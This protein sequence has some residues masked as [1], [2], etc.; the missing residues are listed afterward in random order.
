MGKLSCRSDFTGEATLEG[1][2]GTLE[3]WLATLS[4]F[5]R[6]LLDLI[7]EGA[8][9]EA[10]ST[11]RLTRAG[12]LHRTSVWRRLIR[13]EGYGVVRRP[14]G[15]RGGWALALT[16][17]QTRL[18]GI[19]SDHKRHTGRGAGMSTMMT[20]LTLMG[21]NTPERTLRYHLT[22]LGDMRTLARESGPKSAWVIGMDAVDRRLLRALTEAAEDERL[23]VRSAT[24]VKQVNISRRTLRFYLNRMEAQGAIFRPYGPKRGWVA[25]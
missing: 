19:V 7:R 25:A 8:Q 3:A 17:F 6:R 20:R 15:T 21:M 10:V 1:I 4:P 11:A 22:K 23:S 14:Y 16:P 24:L 13:W 9:V 12:G 18:M 5:E 2:D